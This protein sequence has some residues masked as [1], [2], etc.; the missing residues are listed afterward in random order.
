MEIFLLTLGIVAFTILGR[1]VFGSM[2]KHYPKRLLKVRIHHGYMGLVLMAIGSGLGLEEWI[3][4]LGAA[5][6]LSD[7]LHHFL[8][9]PLWVGKTE[10]P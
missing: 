10:F 4:T 7:V 5:L 1:A 3:F 2:K 8:I 6:F 9:L